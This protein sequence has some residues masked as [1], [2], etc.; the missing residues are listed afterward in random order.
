MNCTSENGSGG[1]TAKRAMWLAQ[2]QTLAAQLFADS[3]A[4]SWG[5]Q[6]ASFCAVLERSAQKRFGGSF[7]GVA[8]LQSY[9][10]SL[11]LQD[12]ALACACADCVAQRE[13]LNR[14]VMIR[15]RTVT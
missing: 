10:S 9:L 8:Q 12:L 2:Q 14:R 3:N 4:T 5:L 1:E 13:W 6:L 15:G 11:H 7:P